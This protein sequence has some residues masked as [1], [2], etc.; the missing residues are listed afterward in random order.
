[1]NGKN[2]CAAIAARFADMLSPVTE[3]NGFDL[4]DAEYVCE[5]SNWYLRA[6]I[7]RK[8]GAD[9]SIGDCTLVSRIVSKQLDKEDFIDDEY[10]LEV[11]SRG[12]MEKPQ[13]EP[14]GSEDN[15]LGGEQE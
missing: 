11:C 14:D 10:T 12:F 6:Y 15:E 2:D 3:K 8:D 1:M 4:I 5:G 13:T 7:S 9:I